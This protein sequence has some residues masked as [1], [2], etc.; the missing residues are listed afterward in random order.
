MYE[1]QL[2][3]LREATLVALYHERYWVLEAPEAYDKELGLRT[4]VTGPDAERYVC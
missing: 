1:W 2:E 3:R 4:D